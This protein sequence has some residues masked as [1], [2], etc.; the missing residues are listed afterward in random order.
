MFFS[1]FFL[2]LNLFYSL[3]GGGGGGGGVG[4]MKGFRVG[5]T[6]S[7][8]WEL[9]PKISRGRGIQMLISTE[10]HITCDFPGGVQ[11]PL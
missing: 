1:F 2:V 11:T 5:P 4:P 3:Q 10:N 6:F 8:G 9:D 7:G